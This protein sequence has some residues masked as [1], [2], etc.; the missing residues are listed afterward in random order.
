MSSIIVAIYYHP[1]LYPPTLNAIGELA[2]IYEDVFVVYRATSGYSKWTYPD[3]VKTYPCGEVKSA[4][5]YKKEGFKKKIETFFF[6]TW[7]LIK[8]NKRKRPQTVLLFDY[9]PTLSW[10]MCTLL[11]Q[12]KKPLVWYHNHDVA[13]L[14]KI[15]KYS[16]S[17]FAKKAEAS[18]LKRG[19]DLFTLPSQ[20][21]LVHFNTDAKTMVLPNYPSIA[22]YGKFSKPECPELKIKLL[23]QGTISE[24][25]GLKEITQFIAKKDHIELHLA[26]PDRSVLVPDIESAA[27][28]NKVF[29]HGKLPYN[30]LPKLTTS[31]HIG[32]AINEPNGII[33]RTGGTASNKIYEYAACGLPILYFDNIH[34]NRYLGKYSWAFATNLTLESL[35]NALYEIVENYQTL[36]E[37]ARHTFETELNYQSA[38]TE[39]RK[40]LSSKK[41]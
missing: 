35:T 30:E 4:D 5:E 13:E 39:V 10:F 6:F 3:N 8:L 9:I 27:G 22:F 28:E 36:S 24:G 37:N 11:V 16:I 38:F 15:R 19:I 23:Y 18:L 17:W 40:F 34:Y 26:G 1:I 12:K 32:I 25:H 14:G 21:R 31:C 41:F 2:Q 33:Y 7:T 20:E 29:Y